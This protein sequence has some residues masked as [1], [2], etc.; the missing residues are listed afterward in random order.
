LGIHDLFLSKKRAGMA[1]SQLS[2]YRVNWRTNEQRN[3]LHFPQATKSSCIIYQQEI[4]EIR[5]EQ[6]ALWKMQEDRA[7]VQ[8]ERASREK[9]RRRLT[10][11]AA[12]LCAIGFIL[13]NTLGY[14]GGQIS[15]FVTALAVATFVPGAA[16]FVILYLQSGEASKSVMDERDF[17]ETIAQLAERQG[18]LEAKFEVEPPVV[19]VNNITREFTDLERQQA[20]SRVSETITEEVLKRTFEEK[21]K[22]LEAQ[23]KK[24]AHSEIRATALSTVERLRREITDLR[25]RSNVNLGIGM[26]ITAVGLILLWSTVAMID[27]SVVLKSL[28]SEG[29]DSNAKFVKSLVLPIIPRMMLVIF[30]EVFAYFFLRLYSAGLTDMKYFQNELTNIESKLVATEFATDNAD[31]LKISLEALAKTERNFILRKDETTVEL[32]RAKAE[33]ELTRNVLKAIP[34]LFKKAKPN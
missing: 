27:T 3:F 20:I 34:E 16:L 9:R 33:S 8:E 19:Q 23:L 17:L 22:A 2:L 18:E 4:K 29:A 25:L 15:L 32:E 14:F 11:S 26:A 10:A 7:K 31:A 1:A 13:F 30:V 24:A 21:A 12:V 28:A 5:M 6:Y